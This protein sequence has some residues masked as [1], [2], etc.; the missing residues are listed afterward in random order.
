M[1]LKDAFVAIETKVVMIACI[2]PGQSSNEHTLNTL[3]YAD[4]LKEMSP[5]GNRGDAHI[6][7]SAIG[8]L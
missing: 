7:T 4:R 5:N 1:I 6:P 2:N 3:R 8:P